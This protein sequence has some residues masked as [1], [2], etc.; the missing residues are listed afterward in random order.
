MRLVIFGE[1]GDIWRYSGYLVVIVYVCVVSDGVT[2]RVW[3]MCVCL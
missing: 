3:Y 1:I 2:E